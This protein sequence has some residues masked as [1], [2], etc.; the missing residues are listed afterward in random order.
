MAGCGH[1]YVTAHGEMTG[2]WAGETAQ[3]GLRILVR[4]IGSPSGPIVAVPD[5]GDVEQVYNDFSTTNFNVVQ[6]FKVNLPGGP[7]DETL[8]MEDIAE[9]F[10]TWMNAVRTYQSTL[11]RWTH[12]KIAPIERGTGKYLAPSSILTLKSPIVG[13]TATSMPPEVSVACSM[14]AG[15]VGKRG[16]GRI[17]LP[18]PPTNAASAD[19]KVGSAIRT[20]LATA[21][22]TLIKD[23]EDGPGLDT[24]KTNVVVMSAPN[25]TAVIPS[26][27]RVGDHFDVQR[28][29]QHQVTEVYTLQSL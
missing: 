10:R 24:N 13:A 14:R 11:F 5:L 29:R 23:L 28:R 15:I 7:L 4:N 6:T 19:G 17:Y 25:T 21:L 16:R 22:H 12:V 26:E 20:S 1:F 3:V 2:A 9:D 27:V 18:F 8:W